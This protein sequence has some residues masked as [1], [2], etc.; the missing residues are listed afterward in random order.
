MN[1]YDS[2]SPLLI[3]MMSLWFLRFRV[4][5][6]FFLLAFCYIVIFLFALFDNF[7]PFLHLLKFIENLYYL[8]LLFVWLGFVSIQGILPR[9]KFYRPCRTQRNMHE[10]QNPFITVTISVNWLGSLGSGRKLTM[11]VRS[12]H[13]RNS[14]IGLRGKIDLNQSLI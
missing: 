1:E 8:G 13:L 14:R 2:L 6:R 10:V 9:S 5:L 11:G 7:F 12:F 3:R 4:F